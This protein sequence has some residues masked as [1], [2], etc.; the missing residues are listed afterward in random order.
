MTPAL[1][2][3]GHDGAEASFLSAYRSGRLHH[4]WLI[5]GP[6][7]IGKARLAERI[8]A[9]LL[10]ARGPASSPFDAPADDPVMRA[11]LAGNHPDMSVQRR[12]LN[13]KGK[14][15]QDI[16]VEQIRQ[17]TQFFSMKPAMRGWRVGIVDAIDEANRNSANALLKTLEEPPAQ[18]ILLLV[19]HRS[20]PILPTIRSRCRVLQLS[21]LTDKDCL[22]ALEAAGAPNDAARLARGRPG[23]GLRLASPAAVNAASA[24]RALIK[25]MPKPADKLVTAA[26]T[27]ASDGPEAGL[28]FR[29]EILDWVARTAETEPRAAKVWL[30]LARLSGDAETLNMDTAQVASKIIAAMHDAATG[31]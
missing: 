27:A 3:F 7:G 6:S 30:G 5:E 21:V 31:K 24:A 20:K 28:A 11:I 9:Y 10:G 4:A 18:S 17:M 29:D 26:L 2:L 22:R 12:Q 13:D 25:A 19:N 15:T 8:A 16:T 1:P 23:L 14:L